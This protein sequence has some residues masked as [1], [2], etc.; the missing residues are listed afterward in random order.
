[1]STASKTPTRRTPEQQ[2]A[3]LQQQLAKT[4]AVLAE[5]AR[6]RRTRAL[7]V[8]GGT[9]LN[10]ADQALRERLLGEIVLAKEREAVKELFDREGK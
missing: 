1:M 5:Q 2:L 3:H 7:I 8:L 4:K 10:I 6:R 9:V